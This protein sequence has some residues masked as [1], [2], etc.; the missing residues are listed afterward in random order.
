MIFIEKPYSWWKNQ[1]Q[2]KSMVLYLKYIPDHYKLS[3]PYLKSK[4]YILKPL[5]PWVL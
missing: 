5:S 2:V 1:T 4:K 3:P